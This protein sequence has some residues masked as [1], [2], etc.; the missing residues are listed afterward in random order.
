MPK[1]LLIQPTQYGPDGRP[2]RQ[3]RIYLPGLVFP[4]LAAIAPRHWEIDVRIEVVDEIDCDADADL[5]G[6][7]TMGYTIFRGIEIAAEFRRR[8][9]QVFMGGYMASLVPTHALEHV[10]SVVVGDAEVSFPRLLADFERT[11]R[12]ERIYD[13]PVDS[14]A[15]LPVPRYDLLTSKPIGGMLPV[16]AGRGCPHLCSFC[17]IACIYKGRYMARPLDEVIR[18]VA[19][20]RDLGYRSFYLLDDNI[21]SEPRFLEDLCNALIPL[22]MTWA[23]QCSLQLARN[24]RLLGLVARSGCN[25]MSFGLESIAQE[26]LDRLGKSWV[27][28]AEHEA[29]LKRI[30]DAGI[31][32][33]SEMM[34]GLDSDTDA[35][36][37]ATYEF[38]ER[39]RIPIPRFYI[40]TP[41]PGSAMYDEMRA[42]GRLVHEDWRRYSGSEAVHRPERMT[43]EALTEGY[44]RLNERVFSLG[45]I[46]RRT[47]FHPRT[48]R[49]PG[50]QAFAFG[51]NMHYR[52]YVRRRVP[53]NIF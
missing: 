5:V 22:K 28:V 48:L 30:E 33:S 14:L 19:A 38:V 21:V 18:D 6:I 37:D 12:I 40:L 11:G 35:T 49:H 36:I 20:V 43:P 52:K 15:G 27:K 3:D 1:L 13:H 45:S 23:S 42:A 9:K 2:C 7:G 16:Q 8:G 53:P 39:A 32:A 25:M 44:W 47:L 50:Q 24:P 46:L 26:G 4:L 10:D 41:G 17:S 29:L 34:V 51:V 31:L